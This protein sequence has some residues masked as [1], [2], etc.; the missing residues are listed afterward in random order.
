MYFAG[1]ANGATVTDFSRGQGV[2]LVFSGFGTEA[3]GATLTQIGTTDQWQIHSGLDSHNE[4]IT[5]ANHA[6]AN[7]GDFFFV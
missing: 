2:V 3:E 7:A 5:F 4:A 1:S 6:A